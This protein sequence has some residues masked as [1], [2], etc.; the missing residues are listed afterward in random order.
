[1]RVK[2]RGKRVEGV[3]FFRM[4]THSRLTQVGY[5]APDEARHRSY[6]DEKDGMVRAGAAT[7]TTRISSLAR[8]TYWQP[9]RW[10]VVIC[11]PKG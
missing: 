8:G 3:A 5:P 4:D 9:S 1:M 11:L 7:R 2:L 10:N 6:L